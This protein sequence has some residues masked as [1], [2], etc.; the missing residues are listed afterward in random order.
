MPTPYTVECAECQEHYNRDKR[1]HC[2]NCG[3]TDYNDIDSHEE[4]ERK[5]NAIDLGEYFAAT[6]SAFSRNGE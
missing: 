4:R 6:N 2:P 1:K 3:E 5:L